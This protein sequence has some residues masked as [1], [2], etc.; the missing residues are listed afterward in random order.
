MIRMRRSRGRRLRNHEGAAR[1]WAAGPW[2]A[3]AP[4]A[5][6]LLAGFRPIDLRRAPAQGGTIRGLVV[7]EGKPVP[8]ALIRLER[9]RVRAIHTDA[10][11]RF[12]LERLPAA[13]YAVSAHIGVCATDAPVS[14]ALADGDVREIVLELHPKPSEISVHVVDPKN[15]PIADVHVRGERDWWH[16]GD[17]S[18]GPPA[19]AQ[20]VLKAMTDAHGD[21]TLKTIGG[22]PFKVYAGDDVLGGRRVEVK[23]P[24][25]YGRVNVA[26]ELGGALV[27][28]R[29][30]H[31]DGRP[32]VRWRYWFVDAKLIPDW[33]GVRPGTTG[34][35]GT[36]VLRAPPGTWMIFAAASKEEIA[37]AK[38]IEIV[39][40]EDELEATLTLEQGVEIR[41]RVVDELG[42][43]V[44]D[45]DVTAAPEPSE[46]AQAVLIRSGLSSARPM[47]PIFEQRTY[48]KA[49]GTFVIGPV[50]KDMRF[51]VAA[52]LGAP[53][54]AVHAHAV[55]PERGEVSI[56]LPPLGGVIKGFVRFEGAPRP[57][58]FFVRVGNRDQSCDGRAGVFH[59]I[60]PR[61]GEVEISIWADHFRTARRKVRVGQGSHDAVLE[62]IVLE[63]VP[64]SAAL[65]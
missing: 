18:D 20:F 11:G 3:L 51:D 21:A 8:S 24:A 1:K 33:P 12:K 38:A 19:C 31:A 6:V 37:S 44:A 56:R 40:A 57:R 26:I 50:P 45:Q 49:D 35:D 63:R 43:P 60:A 52:L 46:R 32:A 47:P 53:G 10:D 54:E 9:A 62:D 7:L 59:V 48:T 4:I 61:E 5:L 29:V 36:F 23:R 14:F 25:P 55:V 16:Q 41:G 39:S 15:E 28:G 13:R 30:V 22:A 17:D 64:E 58:R 65:F 27:R 34:P 42:D 2:I